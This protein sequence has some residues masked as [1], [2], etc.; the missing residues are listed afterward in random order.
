MENLQNKVEGTAKIFIGGN[1]FILSKKSG[2]KEIPDES[3]RTYCSQ[4]TRNY[5]LDR[6]FFE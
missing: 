4:K 3:D 6:Y 5:Q 2:E 1:F